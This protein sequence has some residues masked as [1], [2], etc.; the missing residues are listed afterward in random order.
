MSKMQQPKITNLKDIDNY[1]K[2]TFTPD[3]KRFNLKQLGHD[4]IQLMKKRVYD[5]AGTLKVKVYLN[6]QLIK[7]K[8]FDEYIKYYGQEE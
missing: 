3:F 1:T 2:I 5:L 6:G 4:M 7:I 8:S